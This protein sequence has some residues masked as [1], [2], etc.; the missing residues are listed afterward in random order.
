MPKDI[1]DLA[2]EWTEDL[3]T[4]GE[5]YYDEF[6][7]GRPKS[8]WSPY[9]DETAKDLTAGIQISDLTLT[10]DDF[11]QELGSYYRRGLQSSTSQ[12]ADLPAVLD[13]HVSDRKLG[14]LAY[15]L[16]ELSYE[17]THTESGV[18]DIE[19]ATEAVIEKLLTRHAGEQLNFSNWSQ[20]LE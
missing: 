10:R 14:L 2:D 11:G 3:Q 1:D 20:S 19:Q 6:L 9:I 17:L 16:N 15:Q 4:S 8:E 7:V 13:D 18:D 12:Y 5:Q